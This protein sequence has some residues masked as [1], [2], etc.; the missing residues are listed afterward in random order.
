[1][2]GEWGWRKD[3]THHSPTPG[4]NGHCHLG[5][6]LPLALKHGTGGQDAGYRSSFL[7][8][9]LWS[10]LWT[11]VSGL[12]K[13]QECAMEKHTPIRQFKDSLL[14]SLITFWSVL[15]ETHANWG[16]LGVERLGPSFKLRCKNC[17]KSLRGWNT[18]N[19]LFLWFL[20]SFACSFGPAG[21]IDT[22]LWRPCTYVRK[23]QVGGLG[24]SSR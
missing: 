13:E 16:N 11:V 8:F 1:M 6:W 20:E 24:S 5:V 9:G 15:Y 21:V 3:T 2:K 17:L 4:Q 7:G 22:G 14:S 19:F 10:T 12:W 18:H 23:E